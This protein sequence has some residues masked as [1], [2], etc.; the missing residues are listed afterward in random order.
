MAGGLILGI[1]LGTS[2]VKAAVFAPDGGLRGAGRGSYPVDTPRPGWAETDPELWWKA[3]AEAVRGALA[4]C[5]RGG[6]EIAAVGLDVL[7]PAVVPMAADGRPLHAALL[8]CDQRGVAQVEAIARTLGRDAYEARIGNT[9]APG[10]TAVSNMAWLREERPDVFRTARVLG[11]ASTFLVFRLTGVFT[12]DPTMASLSGLADIRDPWSWDADLCGLLG[13]PMDILPPIR[14]PYEAV[15]VVSGSAAR[16]TGLRAGTPVISGWGDTPSSA[17]GAGASEPGCAAYTAGSTD[18]V[19]VPLDEPPAKDSWVHSAYGLRGSWLAIG[20]NAAGG[21]SVQWFLR[22]ILGEEGAEGLDRFNALAAS[23][24]PGAHGLLFLPHLQ[25]ER[26]PLWDPRARGV[27]LGI[28]TATTRADMARA[29]LEGVA[30]GLRHMVESGEEAGMRLREIRAC[31]GGTRSALWNRIKASVL[32]REILL[33]DRADTAVLGAALM[34]GLG[35]GLYRDWN[36][37]AA[38]P[39]SVRLKGTVEPEQA[40]RRLYEDRYALYREAYP[41]TRDLMHAL[42]EGSGDG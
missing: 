38:V 35:C 7:Y 40:L 25:G 36:E 20:A 2:G 26:T 41:K 21:A 19:A 6:A 18:C 5:P 28:T 27:F 13:I 39:R 32:G 8:Y 15:G 11:F 17:F 42:A 12:A 4:S 9:A 3:T 1:D 23:S 22:E 31:G 34:A 16:D 29:V 14:A 30:F 33:L 24:P 37:A 10:N